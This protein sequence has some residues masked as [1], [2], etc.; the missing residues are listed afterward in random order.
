MRNDNFEAKDKKARDATVVHAEQKR[1]PK[2]RFSVAVCDVKLKLLRIPICWLNSFRSVLTSFHGFIHTELWELDREWD[3]IDLH[4]I[5]W[6]FPHCNLSSTCT[7]TKHQI[8]PRPSQLKFRVMK[9]EVLCFSWCS[10]FGPN[11]IYQF[12]DI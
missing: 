11:T 12:G 5:M 10:L 9:P 4:N 6:K 2:R 8:G 1:T 3:I 7:H